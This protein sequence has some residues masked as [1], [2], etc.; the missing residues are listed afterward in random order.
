M[1]N[2]DVLM[3]LKEWKKEF[4]DEVA[5]YIL[6][7]LIGFQEEIIRINVIEDTDD[8][9]KVDKINLFFN[10]FATIA[11]IAMFIYV[12]VLFLFFSIFSET[13]VI[14]IAII[15]L[16]L[17][18]IAFLGVF[19]SDN[20][21]QKRLDQLDCEKEEQIE[22]KAKEIKSIDLYYINERLHEKY[23]VIRESGKNKIKLIR[24]SQIE[25]TEDNNI[26][27]EDQEEYLKY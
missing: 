9:K 18:F 14:I 6:D 20:I 26:N 23:T 5:V 13:I 16:A 2:E 17:V 22:E 12:F 15:V 10:Y 25:I 8:I 1:D 24:F 19:I 27:I 7:K 11:G 4:D 21:L 3:L